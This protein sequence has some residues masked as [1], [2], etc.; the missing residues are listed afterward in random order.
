MYIKENKSFSYNGVA[1]VGTADVAGLKNEMFN[2]VSVD[3]D[4]LDTSL[5]ADVVLHEIEHAVSDKFIEKEANGNIKNE[6]AVLGNIL[7]KAHSQR[8]RAKHP[9]VKYI[10][11]SMNEVGQL[12]GIK[13]LVAI[14]KE[15]DSENVFKELNELAGVTKTRSLVQRIIDKIA[16][17]FN[18]KTIDELMADV[19]VYTL[20]EAVQNIRLK[21]REDKG[22]VKAENATITKLKDNI[23]SFCK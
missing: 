4:V 22:V 3:T 10:L 7:D 6:Y 17:Y 2:R 21:A 18:T 13:E 12:Q 23:S 11:D 5:L 16:D 1:Y 9:R 19:D 8:A 14:S 15:A 20:H